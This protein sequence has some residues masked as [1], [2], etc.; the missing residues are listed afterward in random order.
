MTVACLIEKAFHWPLSHEENP[1]GS[2]DRYW[3]VEA[4]NYSTLSLRSGL[5]LHCWV[6]RLQVRDERK[7]DVL[8]DGVVA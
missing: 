2:L 1:Y 4:E 7:R 8:H 3:Q 6:Y 5:K